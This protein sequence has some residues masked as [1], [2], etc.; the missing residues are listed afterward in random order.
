MLCIEYMN[1]RANGGMI[2]FTGPAH[3][4]ALFLPSINGPFVRF[5]HSLKE[6]T[7]LSLEP[8]GCHKIEPTPGYVEATV[9]SFPCYHPLAPKHPP[10]AKESLDQ[11]GSQE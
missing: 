1:E 10:T 6:F 9:T 7:W 4:I 8:G 3:F 11:W 5:K 2:T